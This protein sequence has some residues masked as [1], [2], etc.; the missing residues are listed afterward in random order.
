LA[1]GRSGQQPIDGRHADGLLF[2][3]VLRRCGDELTREHLLEVVTHFHGVHLLGGFPGTSINYSAT[4]YHALKQFQL[5]RWEGKHPVA[6]GNLV[7]D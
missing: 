6:F 7:S 2:A 1:V 3:E 4:D 5:F